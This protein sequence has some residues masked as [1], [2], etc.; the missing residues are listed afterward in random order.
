[1]PPT[2][3]CD[4]NALGL[5]HP[6]HCGVVAMGPMGFLAFGVNRAYHEDLR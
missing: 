3:G 5:V 2:F 1:M 4:R 6:L